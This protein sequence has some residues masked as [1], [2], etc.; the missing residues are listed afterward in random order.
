VVAALQGHFDDVAANMA[1]RLPTDDS[2]A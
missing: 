1:R 2:S